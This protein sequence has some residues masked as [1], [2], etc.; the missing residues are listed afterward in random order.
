MVLNTYIYI[1]IYTDLAILWLCMYIYIYVYIYI[2]LFIYCNAII[3][4]QSPASSGNP[5]QATANNMMLLHTSAKLQ[6]G[7]AQLTLLPSRPERIPSP[8]LVFVSHFLGRVVRGSRFPVPISLY[9]KARARSHAGRHHFGLAGKPSRALQ[10]STCWQ[11]TVHHRYWLLLQGQATR[12][13]SMQ[14]RGKQSTS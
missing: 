8:Q 10:S 12:W 5:Q 3:Y 13:A 2:Y 4:L 6:H 7:P 14:A 9:V 1:Y 11:H